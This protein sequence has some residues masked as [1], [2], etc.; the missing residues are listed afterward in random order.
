[1]PQQ[2]DGILSVVS[3]Q[4]EAARYLD[5]EYCKTDLIASKG[6][7]FCKY[8][9]ASAA[10]AAL[11]DISAKGMVRFPMIVVFVAHLKAMVNC[12]TC[13]VASACDQS[14]CIVPWLLLKQCRLF[15]MN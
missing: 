2:L 8:T 11:E 12:R 10:L 15:L 4:E 7:A 13:R 14:Q 3:F 6:V 1:M 5:L 9:K